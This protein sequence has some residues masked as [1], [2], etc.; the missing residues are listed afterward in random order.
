MTTYV[1]FLR[2]INVG[3]HK[4]IKMEDLRDMLAS[5]GLLEVKTIIQSGNVS[6]TFDEANKEILRNRI[7]KGLREKLG[8][9]VTMLLR[10][11]EEINYL[12][13]SDPFGHV[14][15]DRKTK[16]YVSFL[17]RL[18]E[19]QVRLPLINEKEGLEVIR[20]EGEEAFVISR[21]V[22]GRYGFPNNFIEKELSVLATTRNWNTIT[23]MINPNE[24][25]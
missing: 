19:R 9:A 17:Y 20:M 11:R 15:A 2:G 22:N 6:F 16:L 4:V 25:A 5:M 13:R 1:G 21:E 8:Y 7:E 14:V 10:T 12:L 23:R 24:N 3:G 18:P